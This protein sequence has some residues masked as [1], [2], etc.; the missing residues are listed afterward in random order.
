[1]RRLLVTGPA[2]SGT[3]LV[4]RMLGAHPEIEMAVDPLFPLFRSLRNAL[5]RHAGDP[6]VRALSDP[7][8]PLQDYYFTAD[9]IRV[10]DAIQAGNLNVPFDDAE[11][12]FL[13]EQ[14]AARATIESPHLAD[15]LSALRG[16]TYRDLFDECFCVI[17]QEGGATDDGWVGTKEVWVIEFFAA[18]HRAYPDLRMIVVQRDPRAIVASNLG[19]A[20]T[21]PSQV[22]HVLSFARHWRKQEA[23]VAHY[24]TIPE[25]A[26]SL[27]PVRYEHLLTDP[28]GTAEAVCAFL[29]IRVDPAMI[30]S[31]A[32]R[33]ADGGV[34]TANTSFESSGPGIRPELA[35]RWRTSLPPTTVALVELVCGAEMRVAGY[36]PVAPDGGVRPGP[37]VLAE[38]V[39]EN[40]REWSWRS[41]LGDPQRDFDCELTRRMM[42]GDIHAP[43]DAAGIR[44][45]F[46]FPEALA[47]LRGAA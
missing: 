12:A 25:L 28:Q 16:S 41:D 34:W 27:L 42:V 47:D 24:R 10:L 21:D 2:R 33:G 40:E 44:Q 11:R 22:A 5:V 46:L 3:T 17:A 7:S 43:L 18:L 9:R 31:T 1:V 29:G 23:F 26:D 19:M 15:G 14:L 6:A 39:D 37:E 36:K 32:Y 4:A 38:L 8:A 45:A 35:E 13:Q 20:R 30:D